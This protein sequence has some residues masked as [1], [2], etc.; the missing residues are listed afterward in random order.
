MTHVKRKDGTYFSVSDI[1]QVVLHPSD[2]IVDSLP[3][4]PLMFSDPDEKEKK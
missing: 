2:E 1:D 4:P 3:R